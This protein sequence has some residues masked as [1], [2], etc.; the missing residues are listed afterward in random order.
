MVHE[1]VLTKV[2]A[3]PLEMLQTPVV[4]EVNVGVKPE[5]DVAASVGVVPKLCAD[6]CANVMV[7]VPC[8]VTDTVPDAALNP[9]AL[10]AL[11]EQ[12]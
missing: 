12:V 11:T 9:T 8:G 3:P 7:C 5:V 6:G 10:R 1:P 4:V 2:N